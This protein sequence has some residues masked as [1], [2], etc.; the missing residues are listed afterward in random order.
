MDFKLKEEHEMIRQSVRDF[1]EGVLAPKVAERDEQE[2]YDPEVFAK[3][4]ELGLTGIP[5]NPQRGLGFFCLFRLSEG[6]E[7]RRGGG[8]PPP[9]CFFSSSGLGCG[10][11]R[12]KG[13]GK[14]RNKNFI[15]S[16]K[17]FQNRQH[18]KLTPFPLWG[19]K[20]DREG[21]RGE[22]KKNFFLLVEGS[23]RSI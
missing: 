6:G 3:M 19:V 14:E 8:P 13:G 22:E 10:W 12:R 7:R 4:A 21:E 15:F 11:P 23:K 17:R 2:Y 16:P 5:L 20:I 9:S 18:L 1:A